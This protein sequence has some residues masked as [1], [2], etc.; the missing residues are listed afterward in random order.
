MANDEIH[1]GAASGTHSV[2]RVV[3]AQTE[4]EITDGMIRAAS[5]LLLRELYDNSTIEPFVDEIA[6]E[7]LVVA[8]KR[9][10][11][12]DDE[13]WARVKEDMAAERLRRIEAYE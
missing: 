4:I 7:M 3:D 5:D 9:M 2:C 12:T 1:W 13:E 8:L 6:R 10:R 11:I